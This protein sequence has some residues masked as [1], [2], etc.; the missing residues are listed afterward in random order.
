[1][2]LATGLALIFSLQIAPP[3]EG[4]ERALHER[5]SL[6]PPEGLQCASQGLTFLVCWDSHVP[7]PDIERWAFIRDLV[8]EEF[9]TIKRPPPI[10]IYVHRYSNYLER[11]VEAKL[12][13]KKLTLAFTYRQNHGGFYVVETWYLVGDQVLAHEFAHQAFF[14][15]APRYNVEEAADWGS[16]LLVI[17]PRYQEWLK[18]N[19]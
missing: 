15:V 11:R 18:K 3:G 2:Q 9:P 1:M 13:P 16:R 19:R 6:A 12:D 4:Q 8:Y 14:I 10:R 7:K 5:P 17:N